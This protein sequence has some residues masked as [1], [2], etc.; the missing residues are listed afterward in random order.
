MRCDKCVRKAYCQYLYY[1]NMNEETGCIDF[2]N[3]EY[4]NTI[5]TNTLSKEN[6]DE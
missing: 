6:K 4:T 3:V 1:F 2:Q 5:T